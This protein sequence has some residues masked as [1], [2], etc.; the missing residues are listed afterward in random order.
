MDNERTNQSG[1]W[2]LLEW[3]RPRYYIEGGFIRPIPG[4]PVEQVNPFEVE[5]EQPTHKHHRPRRLHEDLAAV[6]PADQ[7]SLQSFVDRW[8]L[9]GLI[10]HVEP[11]D[12]RI[13]SVELACDPVDQYARDEPGWVRET[14]RK[15]KEAGHTLRAYL[16]APVST[17]RLWV[18]YLGSGK[19]HTSEQGHGEPDLWK[20]H[21]G[22]YFPGVNRLSQL[23]RPQRFQTAPDP[24]QALISG[25]DPEKFWQHYSEPV[26][27]FAEQV[28]EFRSVF[29][30]CAAWNEGNRD[31]GQLHT[32]MWRFTHYLEDV[33][34]TP[35]Y[36]NYIDIGPIP[37]GELRRVAKPALT[38]SWEWRW[39]FP[40]L[41]SAAYLMLLEAFTGAC[42]PRR[43]PSESCRRLF[44]PDRPN[45]LYC[46]PECQRRQK[47]RIFRRSKQRRNQEA[48]GRS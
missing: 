19:V 4:S 30:A 5:R 6:D 29:D 48:D 11:R 18:D 22:R 46:S 16:Q 3:V 23:L 21:Y 26:E 47:Q 17:S 28:E 13:H 10:Q 43:C 15:W 35:Y 20:K 32:F 12:Y 39:S 25:L 38:G 24:Y 31:D 2:L 36:P 37:P 41:L 1:S 27:A 44:I 34:P 7:R 40:S 45:V 9:L 14:E 42:R 8:G 33:H